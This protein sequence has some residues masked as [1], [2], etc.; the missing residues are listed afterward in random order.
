M[1]ALETK[2][3]ATLADDLRTAARAFDETVAIRPR[4]PLEIRIYVYV[5]VLL[6]LIIFLE[7][8]RVDD[9]SNS[10]AVELN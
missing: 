5:D 10:C 7:N 4:A 3:E 9:A 1:L 6:E 8:V 2:D